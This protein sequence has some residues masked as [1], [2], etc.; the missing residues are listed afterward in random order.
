M[1]ICVDKENK[2]LQAEL[3][4]AKA[5]FVEM[6]TITQRKEDEIK[7]LHS[8]ELNNLKAQLTQEIIER[9]SCNCSN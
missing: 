6:E 3:R 5:K 1:L 4:D 9:Y 2:S 7:A 8:T